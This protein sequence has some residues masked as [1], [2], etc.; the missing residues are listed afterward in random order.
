MEKLFSAAGFPGFGRGGA[1]QRAGQRDG[2]W[3]TRP[4]V[5]PAQLLVLDLKTR[6]A[7]RG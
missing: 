5:C 7:R 4:D 3:S 2:L 6:M 1:S